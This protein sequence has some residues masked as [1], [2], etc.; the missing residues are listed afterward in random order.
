MDDVCI[1]PFGVCYRVE[2]KM[3][4]ASDECGQLITQY[5]GTAS[6]E[7]RLGG[8]GRDDREDGPSV[9]GQCS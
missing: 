2:G 8:V 5:G 4:R 6:C 1:G 9:E 7:S 3:G